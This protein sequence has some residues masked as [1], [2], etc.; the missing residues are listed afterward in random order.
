MAQNSFTCPL[1]NDPKQYHEFQDLFQHLQFWHSFDSDF[2]L[3]CELSYTCGKTYKT[4]GAFKSHVHRFHSDL[5]KKPSQQP[6]YNQDNDINSLDDID[7]EDEDYSTIGA[8]LSDVEDDDNDEETK[9]Q[10]YFDQNVHNNEEKEND[11]DAMPPPPP[12]FESNKTF[13]MVDFQKQYARFLLQMREDHLLP[14]NVMESISNNVSQLLNIVTKLIIQKASDNGNTTTRTHNNNNNSQTTRDTVQNI[15]VE[16]VCSVINEVN[17]VVERTTKTEYKFIKLC[18]RFFGYLPPKEIVLSRSPQ[19]TTVKRSEQAFA[20]YVPIRESL[21]R[22]LCKDEMISLLVENIKQQQEQTT[23]DNDLMFSYRDAAYGQN[24]DNNSFLLQLYTDGVGLT[25]PIGPKKDL[26]KVTFFY[27]LLEDI[28]DMFRSMLQCITLLAVINTNYLQ[29]EQYVKRFYKPVIDDLNALQTTGLSIG[30]F[31]AQLMFKFTCISADNL[32]AHQIGNFQQCFSTGYFCRRCLVQYDLRKIPLTDIHFMPRN[33]QQHQKCL[34][35]INNNNDDSSVCGVVGESDLKQLAGFHP[36]TALSGDAMHDF[37]E[38][39]CPIVIMCLLKRASQNKLLT[40]AQIEERTST[41]VY[42][43]NDKSDQPP[44]IKIKHMTKG[45]LVGS[46]AQKL[47]LFRLFPIIFADITDKLDLFDVYVVL[48]QMVEII[49]AI[50]IRK[51]WLSYLQHLGIRFQSAMAEYFPD[52]MSPKVHFSCEYHDII[53]C[54]GPPTR[55]W[56]MRYEG[57]HLYFKKIALRTCNF[58]NITKTFATRNQY[59]HCLQLSKCQFLKA[60]DEISGSKLEK[61]LNYDENVKQILKTKFNIECLDQTTTILACKQL[62]HD[63]I[64]YKKNSVII[65]DVVDEEDTPL[66]Y[67]IHHMIKIKSNWVIIV[68]KLITETFVEQLYSYEIRSS[69]VIKA[70]YPEHLKFYHKTLDIYYVKGSS[71]ATLSS[72]QQVDGNTLALMTTPIIISGILPNFIEQVKFLH[73]RDRL[74]SPNISSV[75]SS[76]SQQPLSNH[77]SSSHQ[78]QSVLLASSLTQSSSCGDPNDLL[79][80]LSGLTNWLPFNTDQNLKDTKIVDEDLTVTRISTAPDTTTNSITANDNI[81]IKSKKKPIPDNYLLPILPSAVEQAIANGNTTIFEN[82]SKF[83]GI[84]VE[85]IFFD[86]IDNYQAWYPDKREYENVTKSILNTLKMDV[87]TDNIN[88]W[89]QSIQARFKRG[90]KTSAT[91]TDEIL[92][93]RKKYKS[94]TGTGGRPIKK[95][96]ET[97]AK[98]EKDRVIIIQVEEEDEKKQQE[99]INM[100]KQE[101]STD[102]PNMD[103]LI[104]CWRTTLTTRNEFIKKNNL[105]D[106]LVM[107]PGYKVPALIYDEILYT[108]G[109]NLKQKVN[110]CFNILNEKLCVNETSCPSDSTEFRVLKVLCKYMN[111][112]WH[113]IIHCEEKSEGNE[114]KN[115]IKPPSAYPCMLFNDEYFTIMLDFCV[116]YVQEA[117]GLWIACY[118]IFGIQFQPHNRAAKLLYSIIFNDKSKTTSATRKLLNQWGIE[119]EVNVPKIKTRIEPLKI[120]QESGVDETKDKDAGLKQHEKEDH[121]SL[122]TI[123]DNIQQQH[124]PKL[125]LKRKEDNDDDDDNEPLV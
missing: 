15:S 30:T 47:L 17:E 85:A 55:F 87:N 60:F 59:K 82:Y 63:H 79:A 117:V 100:M 35:A 104:Y 66:F 124:T 106:T 19:T 67:L 90:R 112:S 45:R 102:E 51:S 108:H 20:Y 115:D 57:R 96:E 81:I 99:K 64:C 6:V 68:E 32:G 8:A 40:Y 70:I 28:P 116:V 86:L 72:H 24:V 65:Y 3:N 23:K 21:F 46:A 78:D 27:Y 111:E 114:K 113:F 4:F 43:G 120:N 37:C 76:T 16:N 110:E 122:T 42:G 88:S 125:I 10:V 44:T 119:I 11:D 14:L 77:L 1:C 84:L 58:K 39:T 9:R 53:K 101:L 97:F 121:L 71:Y 50:P 105:S 12:R 80:S 73:Y 33:E 107:F 13:T 92:E 61:L 5:L 25:N 48:R 7:A 103:Q 41:F 29:D 38:G 56:C 36:T 89:K 93:A 91:P 2:I 95:K 75:L 69:G 54:F 109:I 18:E 98:R 118:D 123:N 62:I 31:D 74:F 22:I 52:F 26:H 94:E 49:L 83:R 34:D